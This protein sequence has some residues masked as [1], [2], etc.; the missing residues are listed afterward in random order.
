MNRTYNP[1][2]EYLTTVEAAHYLRCSSQ[3]LE[4][5]RCR[6]YGPPFHKLGRAVRYRKS[7]LN[8]WLAAQEHRPNSTN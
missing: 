2:F 4:I 6:G 3:F 5:G 7:A 8:E 1:Q